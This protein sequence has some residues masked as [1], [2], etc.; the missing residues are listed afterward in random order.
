MKTI[1]FP[2]NG[3][4]RWMSSPIIM[5]LGTLEVKDL[6]SSRAGIDRIFIAP[7]DCEIRYYKNN[8]PIL[9]KAN[10]G[11]LIISFIK[12]ECYKHYVVV[13]KNKEFKE[14]IEGYELERTVD[15]LKKESSCTKCCD[16]CTK[17]CDCECSY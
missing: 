12:N 6:T 8:N 14:N 17:C 15:Q 2:N 5:D 16:S 1:I 3:N 9:L 7:E 13:L 11:D 10:K 4:D